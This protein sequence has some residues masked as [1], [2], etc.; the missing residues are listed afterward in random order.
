MADLSD[1]VG[2]LSRESCLRAVRGSVRLY[3]KLRDR[4][5]DGALVRHARAEALSVAYLEGFGN[6]C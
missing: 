6:S 1:T 2:G 5:D 4:L 3:L